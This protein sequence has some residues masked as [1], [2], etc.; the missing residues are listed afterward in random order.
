M[1]TGRSTLGMLLSGLVL[2]GTK[3]RSGMNDPNGTFMKRLLSISHAEQTGCWACAAAPHRHASAAIIVV[4]ASGRIRNARF[5]IGF[6]PFVG[7][8]FLI[9][10]GLRLPL[11][12]RS[13][14]FR[15][16][17]NAACIFPATAPR[18]R[19]ACLR[20]PS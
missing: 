15:F 19:A 7:L 10:I 13:D 16:A 1:F 9:E 11:L 8:S 4:H 18:R 12:F 6:L 3:A 2:P 17:P 14:S 20:S 5:L